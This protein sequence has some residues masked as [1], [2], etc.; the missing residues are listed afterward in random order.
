M[1]IY[2]LIYLLI[3]FFN[4]MSY[5]RKRPELAFNILSILL[6]LLSAF[7]YEIGTDYETYVQIYNQ[8]PPISSIFTNLPFIEPGFYYLG[9]I[10]KSLGLE[11]PTFFF[12]ISIISFSVLKNA[13]KRF[14]YS[15]LLAALLVYF[16]FFYL[17]FHM[18][19]IRHGIMAS[20]VWLAFSYIPEKNFKLF[21]LYILIGI[22]FHISAIIFIPAYWLLNMNIRYKDLR[23]IIP[24]AIIISF[25]PVFQILSKLIPS[26]TM[27]GLQLDFY[28]NQY[29]EGADSSY[30][31]TV[32]FIVNCLILILLLLKKS[33]LVKHLRHPN[34]FLNALIFGLI[35]LIALNKYGVFVERLVSVFYLS[36]ILLIP[37]IVLVFKRGMSRIIV[38]VIIFTY[39]SAVFYKNTHVVERSGEYQY[40]PY[41][42]ILNK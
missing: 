38:Y 23:I 42:T 27:I 41:R 17:S 40:I 3:I 22:S 24:L 5:F 14:N 30:G 19:V 32:G 9:S 10:F 39:L 6:S 33:I 36:L 4:L 25:I 8:I 13:L 34:I 35:L 20:F 37:T 7:R 21:F 1:V 28:I 18:N 26:T 2:L 12:T 16:S 11:S 15:N 31:I 29:Y